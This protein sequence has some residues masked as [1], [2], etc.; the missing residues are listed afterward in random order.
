VV[1]G[2]PNVVRGGSH[3]GWASAASLAERDICTVLCSDYYYPAMLGAA[4]ILADR[5]VLDFAHA[6]GLVTLNP[7]R[8][9]GLTDRGEIAPGKRAD[10]ILVDPAVPRVVA[11]VAAGRLAWI[12]DGARMDTGTSR[13]KMHAGA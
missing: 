12:G 6:W 4:L 9:A 8:A 7:A 2:C 1:M 13:P 11:T 10:L 5:Q 3:L